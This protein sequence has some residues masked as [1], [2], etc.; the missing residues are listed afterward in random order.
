MMLNNRPK[1]AFLSSYPSRQCGIAEHTADVLRSVY[2][3]LD[4]WMVF[5][6]DKTNSSYLPPI[7]NSHVVNQMDSSDYEKVANTVKEYDALAKARKENRW[8][9]DVEHEFGLDGNGTDNNYNL[10][11]KTL[12]EAGI[13]SLIRLH[14]VIDSKLFKLQP[15][16][17][18]ITKEFGDNYSAIIAMSPSAKKVLSSSPYN[19]DPD[20]IHV[21]HHGV[22]SAGITAGNKNE[23]KRRFGLEERTVVGT[24]GMVSSGKG[25]EFSIPGFSAYLKTL[26]QNEK[27]NIN[28]FIYGGTHIEVL[29]HN[30]GKDPYRKKLMT[31]AENEGLNPLEI[32][33]ENINRLR[34]IDLKKHK[35]IFVN[36]HIDRNVLE[37]FFQA[38]DIGI[39]P[40]KNPTQCSSGIGAKLAG[41]GI[42]C[43]STKFMFSNDLFKDENGELDN[44][45]YLV[46]FENRLP[47]KDVSKI[48]VNPDEIAKGLA[49]VVKHYE[50]MRHKILTKGLQRDWTVVGAQQLYLFKNLLKLAA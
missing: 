7:E 34:N 14:T 16:Q 42:P 2:T 20:K 29:R 48:K 23:K 8:L 22:F 32:T 46:K 41:Y 4:K 5:P 25:L 21:V 28:Y 1:V 18:A 39:T 40:Y 47:V 35:V 10:F 15:F 26:N 24:P 43:V 3:D 9:A 37:E 50:E 38:M 45:G 36:S 13:P 33:D 17:L 30:N 44:S 6:I 12:T 27:D 11:G 31:I 49:H 19:I